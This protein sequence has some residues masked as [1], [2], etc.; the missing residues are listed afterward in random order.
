MIGASVEQVASGTS[1]VHAAGETMRRIVSSI[2]QVSTMVA[3]ISRA[4]AEQANAIHGVNDAVSDMDRNT[5]QNAALVEESAAAAES[6]RGQ[7]AGLVQ[8]ISVFH[9]TEQPRLMA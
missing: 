5:Q 3:E 4:T 2:E 6:L 9:V 8:A 1:K 7:A